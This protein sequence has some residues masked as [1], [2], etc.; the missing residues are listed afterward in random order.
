MSVHEYPEDLDV[1]ELLA[2]YTSDEREYWMIWRL[3]AERELYQSGIDIARS[4]GEDT[5][6]LDTALAELP[7]MTALQALHANR[8]LV[9]LLTGRR[10]SVMRRAREEGATWAQI[11]E[12]LGM[13]KQGAQDWYARKI[14]DQ[15]KHAPEFHDAAR[16]RAVLEDNPETTP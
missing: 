2:S 8:R 5:T 15:E 12:A 4:R 16:A 7:P 14:A 6:V 11:G 10:W 13:S 1:A 9:E 3:H